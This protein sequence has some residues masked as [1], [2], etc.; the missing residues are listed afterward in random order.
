MTEKNVKKPLDKLENIEY[1]EPSEKHS[2]FLLAAVV[3]PIVQKEVNE[4]GKDN[5]IL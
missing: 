5:R 2:A 3:Q 4:N 1:N